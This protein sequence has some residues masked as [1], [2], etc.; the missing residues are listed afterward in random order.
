MKNP[1]FFGAPPLGVGVFGKLPA[2]RKRKDRQ[3]NRLGRSPHAP[4][5]PRNRK[6]AGDLARQIEPLPSRSGRLLDYE[7][8]GSPC[9]SRSYRRPGTASLPVTEVTGSNLR[10]ARPG[11]GRALVGNGQTGRTQSKRIQPRVGH[12]GSQ[13]CWW[14]RIARFD[15]PI[16][17]VTVR[18][19][20]ARRGRFSCTGKAWVDA[21]LVGGYDWERLGITPDGQIVR[22]GLLGGVE[23][24]LLAGLVPAWCRPR[25]YL[26]FI[27]RSGGGVGRRPG[28][29]RAS[30]V[31]VPRPCR[32]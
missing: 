6:P 7:S 4:A 19:S 14:R 10:H 11:A 32:K 3:R 9:L 20:T 5:C 17:L 12:V 29:S 18:G 23:R 21:G 1:N 26:H 15:L 30:W 28:V 8:S 24:N 25:S 27:F 31:A 16:P 13:R 2:A 22:E